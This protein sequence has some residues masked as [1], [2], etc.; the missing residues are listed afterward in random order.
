MGSAKSFAVLAG[1]GIT[2]TGATTLSG[3][4][5]ANIG[6]SPTGTFTGDTTVTTTGTKYLAADAVTAA[7]QN[8][9]ITA[10]NDAAG[11]TSATAISADLGGQTLKQGV[12]NSASSI[13]LTGTLT[14]D[15]ENDPA[16]VFIFQAG[17]T[18]TTASASRVNL[19]NGAQPCN[20]F[21][22]VGS[23]ATFG[24]NSD[25][26]GHV[27][28][29]TSITA[30]TG[31]SFKGQ[32]LA[33]NGAVTLD[34][35]TIVND[36]CAA[37]VTPTPTETASATETPTPSETPTPTETASPTETATPTETPSET[38]S[39]TETPTET[40]SETATPTETATPEESASATEEATDTPEVTTATG[41]ELPNTETSEWL[42]PLGIGLGLV[43]IGGA[44][45]LIRRRQNR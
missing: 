25:F 23:S 30:T 6:S 31:A 34:T 4:D 10:Y 15:G 21:W 32:L 3:T 1:S 13:G 24:T 14:L 35:N 5:G 44:V 29:L 38:A 43:A 9:L 41:G 36:A 8:D 11:R 19:I 17:S 33:R 2:N 42:V 28:A 27:I 18:L 39:P 12:Y 45:L 20:V 26:T 22:Q 7:A 37:V 16:A 40:P